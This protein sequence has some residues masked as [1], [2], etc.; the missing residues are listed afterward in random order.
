MERGSEARRRYPS[1]SHVVR[2]TAQH[3]GMVARIRAVRQL[4]EDE[5]DHRVG[6]W[7]TGAEA[8]HVD[9]L[10]APLPKED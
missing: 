10:P 7:E 9:I 8:G 5:P 2:S 6:R 3:A 4:Q 1:G